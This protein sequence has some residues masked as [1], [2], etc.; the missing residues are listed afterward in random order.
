MEAPLPSSSQ[1]ITSIIHRL[2]QF[3]PPPPTAA[4]TEDR[5]D[6]QHDQY[7]YP[8]P[9]SPT[10][11]TGANN[12]PFTQLPGPQLSKVKPLL[13]T[14]HCLFPNELLLALDIL[15][16]KII[17]R[18]DYKLAADA[19]RQQQ[20]QQH[21]R[22]D[23]GVYFIRSSTSSSPTSASVAS[24]YAMNT[25]RG[26]TNYEKSHIV[27]LNAWNCS[28]PAFTLAAFRPLG[29]SSQGAS[30]GERWVGEDRIR[31]AAPVP[32]LFNS[33]VESQ[34]QGSDNEDEDVGFSPV[35]NAG[36]FPFGGTLVKGTMKMMDGGTP[37]CK[38]LLACLLG[39]QC[40]GLFGGGVEEVVV[41]DEKE[42]AGR[43]A[44]G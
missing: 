8:G 1:F 19:A 34:N 36:P 22:N 37:V 7:Q 21:G 35:D 2:S 18:Y 27:C 9:T 43:F 33:S 15:D 42:M 10:S 12:N 5:N 6:D 3:H 39:S 14:L 31:N 32:P 13:L 28:C 38:H 26:N 29:S 11:A 16:R 4:A 24:Y 17:R 23:T 30:E 41:D 40:P 44:A 20:Q 25:T